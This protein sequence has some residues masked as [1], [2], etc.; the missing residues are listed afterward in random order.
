MHTG[1]I[2]P[3]EF[4]R[5]LHILYE[6]K[7]E[8]PVFIAFPS[9]FI[10]TLSSSLSMHP[11]QKTISII[12]TGAL[13]S[14]FSTSFA[15]TNKE[16][17]LGSIDTLNTS[18]ATS[19]AL[20]E[21]TLSDRANELGNRYDTTIKSLGFQ[22]DEVEALT[23]IKTLGVPS[24]RQDI[25]Q[26]YLG[27]KQDMLQNIKTTQ[28]ALTSLRDE[29]A[30]GYAD[31]SVAQKQSYD[32]KIADAQK[33]YATFLSGSTASIDTF[34]NTFSGR[35]LSDTALVI[36]M[37]RDNG[38]YVSFIRDIR[39]GYSRIDEKKANLLS[40]KN[41]FEQEVLPKIQ[42]GFLI[43][44]AN[45]KIFTDAIRKDLTSGLEKAT[46]QERIKKQETELRAYIED[47]MSKWNEHLTKNF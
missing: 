19:I 7:E 6:P 13:L 2:F 14:S 4:L 25:A 37:M 47:I 44:T 35:I 8:S 41:M 39:S 22:S 10:L 5:S 32:T 26:A 9:A 40:R 36:K 29:V 43:F 45:K 18:I 15:L 31:L 3:F 1:E 38:K 46:A 33:N 42:G 28:T 21:K 30:L 17:T 27:L 23:S 24:F 34:T 11:F 16:A 12:L 20:R